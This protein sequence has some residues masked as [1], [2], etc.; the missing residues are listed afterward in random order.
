M[1]I[2]PSQRLSEGAR[3]ADAN[4]Q[5]QGILSSKTPSAQGCGPTSPS[6]APTPEIE[7]A[8]ASAGGESLCRPLSGHRWGQSHDN[9]EPSRAIPGFQ[10]REHALG[11]STDIHRSLPGPTRSTATEARPPARMAS[12]GKGTRGRPTPSPESRGPGTSDAS[13]LAFLG[14]PLLRIGPRPA[15]RTVLRADWWR[16]SR[17]NGALLSLCVRRKPKP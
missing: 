7:V 13:P 17:E 6:P 10:R 8:D 14:Q 3:P 15:P 4:L 9:E 12:W 16:G 1:A 2:S 5:C 11:I